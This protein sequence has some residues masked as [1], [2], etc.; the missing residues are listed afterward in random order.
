MTI[1]NRYAINKWRHRFKF[2]RGYIHGFR[3]PNAGNVVA[4]P[5]RQNSCC[6]HGFRGPNARTLIAFTD[7]VDRT[8]EVSLHS[9]ISW[10]EYRELS[11]RPQIPWTLLHTNHEIPTQW[12]VVVV[13]VA[14]FRVSY[15]EPGGWET[16]GGGPRPHNLIFFTGIFFF[17]NLGLYN[18]SNFNGKFKAFRIKHFMVPKIHQGI[19]STQKNIF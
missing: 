6:V 16:G 10:T 2:G 15:R 5:E 19:I 18:N 1:Y 12:K 14:P 3:V 13:H 9:R 4:S 7:S 11:L 17:E 8:P